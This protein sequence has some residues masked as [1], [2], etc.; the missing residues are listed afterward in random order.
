[1]IFVEPALSAVNAQISA[2]KEPDTIQP[3]NMQQFALTMWQRSRTQAS[4]RSA[5]T[6]LT[7]EEVTDHNDEDED[8]IVI[9]SSKVKERFYPVEKF[10]N[11]FSKTIPT[12]LPPLRIVNHRIDPKPG[13]EWLPSWRPSANKFGQQIND[14]HNAEIKSGP[15]Y[16]APNDKHAVVMFCVAKQDQ[17]DKPRFVKD[18]H[19]R[20][21]AA[22]KKQAPLPNIDELMELVTAYPA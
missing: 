8:A 20:N 11:L 9:A 7:Y 15:M 2:S 18:Y 6:K 14:K 13:S 19:L 10:P 12:E 22:Y 17:P 4:F 5:A 1:M 21:L 3:P 16:P